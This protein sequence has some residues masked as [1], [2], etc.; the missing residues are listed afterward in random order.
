MSETG[1]VYVARVSYRPCRR[2]DNAS[3]ACSCSY[4]HLRPDTQDVINPD[5][6]L[7]YA[8][9]AFL[10]YMLATCFFTILGARIHFE[11]RRHDLLVRSKHLRLQYL[12]SLDER[13]AG[14]IDEEEEAQTTLVQEEPTAANKAA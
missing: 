14:I 7:F 11:T 10:L 8:I 1:K 3:S 2:P 6:M 4:H 5:N 9:I 12:H 13:M